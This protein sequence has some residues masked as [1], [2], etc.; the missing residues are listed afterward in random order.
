MH[1]DDPRR[2]ND[3]FD[4]VERQQEL[5]A[6]PLLRAKEVAQLLQFWPPGT[7]SVQVRLKLNL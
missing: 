4:C 2:G 5:K 6:A 1:R 7:Q 3:R